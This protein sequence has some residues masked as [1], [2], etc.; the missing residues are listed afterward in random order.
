MTVDKMI[1]I[2]LT[3]HDGQYRLEERAYD[4]LARY[5]DRSAARLQDDPDR[6]EVIGDL[7][8]SVG[9]RLSA[10]VGSD[11]RLVTAADIDR[12]L[13][14]IGAVDTGNDQ[15]TE[16]AAPP[17]RARRLRRI[18]EGQQ[19]AGVCTGLS[20]YA[21]FDVDWVRTL[22][23]LGTLV[24]AGILGLVY[25]ALVFILPVDATPETP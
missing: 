7:E 23:V 10:S 3:G 22:F 17:L 16:Q 2:R 13:E 8:R 6:A 11:D 24:T 4:R 9:D 15:G 5:L 18:R 14:E 21:E 19:I 25:I 1:V 12:I 20:D